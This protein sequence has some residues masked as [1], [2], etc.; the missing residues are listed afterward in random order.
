MFKQI[1]SQLANYTLSFTTTVVAMFLFG[2]TPSWGIFL[3]PLVALPLFF[4]GASIG[5]MLSM[6]GIVAVDLNRVIGMVLGFL[7]WTTPIRY[8]DKDPHPILAVLIKYNPL[9]YLV[10]SCR[11]MILH[12]HFYRHRADI[13]FA[14][15]GVSVL[16]FLIA[17]RLFYVSEHKLVERMI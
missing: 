7:I 11:D 3:F 9:T 16:L 4:L 12:G 17:W 2:V 10:C 15:A 5:L 1:A 6:I 13:Y 8:S 14:C